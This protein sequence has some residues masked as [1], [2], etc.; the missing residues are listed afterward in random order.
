MM[1]YFVP[2]WIEPT[3]TTAGSSGSFSRDTS[4]WIASTVRAAITTGSTVLSGAAPWP[5]R[6]KM[7]RSTESTLAI[8]YPGT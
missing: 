5:P 8:A 6:P 1:L 3:V 2:P 4:V 7:V